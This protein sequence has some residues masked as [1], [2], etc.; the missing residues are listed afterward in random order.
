M[1]ILIIIAFVWLA[2]KVFDRA[3]E[4]S[5]KW[6]SGRRER[7]DRTSRARFERDAARRRARSRKAREQRRREVREHN[8]QVEANRATPGTSDW[9]RTYWSQ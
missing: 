2:C 6:E 3:D 8:A 9:S 5:G 4:D 1:D 7:S